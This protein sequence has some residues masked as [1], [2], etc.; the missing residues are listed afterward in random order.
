MAITVY[1]NAIIC[2]SCGLGSPGHKDNRNESSDSLHFQQN[3][4]ITFKSTFDTPHP[5][6]GTLAIPSQ[7]SGTLIV[8]AVILH[9]SSQL[10]RGV[11]QI[12]HG[13]SPGVANCCCLGCCFSTGCLRSI[14]QRSELMTRKNKC[15]YLPTSQMRVLSQLYFYSKSYTNQNYRRNKQKSALKWENQKTANHRLLREGQTPE[16]RI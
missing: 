7:L 4:P 16:H 3:E 12:P 5:M 1:R 9:L 8:D 14:C 15:V 6:V 10:L 11:Q 13:V 2:Y